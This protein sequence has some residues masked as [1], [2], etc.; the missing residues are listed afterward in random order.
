MREQ[1]DS[2]RLFDI[3]EKKEKFWAPYQRKIRAVEGR[4]E[5][6]MLTVQKAEA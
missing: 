5:K 1:K 2:R 6:N 3:E 4:H